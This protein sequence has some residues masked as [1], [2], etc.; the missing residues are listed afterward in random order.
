MADKKRDFFDFDHPMYRPLW[1]RLMLISACLGWGTFE[2]WLG[3]QTWGAIF[4]GIGTFLIY[5][6]LIAFNPK[7]DDRSKP[8]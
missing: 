7:D 5:Q 6:L 8:D 4:M 2:V 1:F 3:N